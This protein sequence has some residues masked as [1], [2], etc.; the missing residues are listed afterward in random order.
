MINTEGS[1]RNQLA[2]A[3]AA[4]SPDGQKIAFVNDSHELHVINA[5]GRGMRR[6]A[7]TTD[8]I[9]SLTLPAWSPDGE[10]IAFPCPADQGGENADLCVI[11]AGD[12][13]EWKRIALNVGAAG[14]LMEVSWGRG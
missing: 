7:K 4:W 6:L 8:I 12:G 14:S 11:N 3:A 13:T 10:K 1:G 2:E 9:P 5:D